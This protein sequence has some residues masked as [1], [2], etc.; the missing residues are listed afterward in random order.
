[1]QRRRQRLEA[2]GTLASGIAHDLNNLL[3]P[4]LMSSRMMQRGG[5]NIDREA[6]LETIVTGASRGAEL[7]AQLLTFARGGDGQH[8]PVDVGELLD[9]VT[10]I[11]EHTLKKEITLEVSAAADLPEV[12]GDATEIS[13]VIMN[14][15]INARDAMPD[16]GT[17]AITATQCSLDAERTY[18][19]VTLQPG[20]YLAISVRDTGMG[21]PP[22]I[23]DRIFDPFF[24]T[25]ERGQGTGLGLS[26]SLGIVRSHSGAV[27]VKSD[28]DS[29]TT[30]T[31]ILPIIDPSNNE[32]VAES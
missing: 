17:L 6:M 5:K 9:E 16:G 23:R 18:S 7:I 3:T 28:V 4:I 1:V 15:A 12:F 13:Q 21:I 30:V 25:K 10:G 2:L 22:S 20:D 32:D 11:L 8:R 27:D 19:L 31:V 26:T 29:G 24:T 14:L